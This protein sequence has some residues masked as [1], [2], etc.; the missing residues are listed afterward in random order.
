MAQ[1]T[2]I[3]I[4]LESTVIES[5]ENLEIPEVE[6]ISIEKEIKK[7]KQVKLKKFSKMLS[8]IAKKSKYN[9]NYMK[10]RISIKILSN[11]AHRTYAVY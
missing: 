11:A 3:K 8:K 10:E 9:A 6:E 2:E 7:G 1:A 5:L 4:D